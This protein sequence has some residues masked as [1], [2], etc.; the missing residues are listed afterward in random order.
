MLTAHDRLTAPN[1]NAVVFA[2][3][4]PECALAAAT[5]H[6]KRVCKYA[7]A[8]PPPESASVQTDSFTASSQQP[9]NASFRRLK[10]H[11]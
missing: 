9:T 4:M 5:S 11:R 6:A 2:H 3:A 8:S 7:S 10:S 1:F